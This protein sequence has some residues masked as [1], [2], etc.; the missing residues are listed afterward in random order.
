MDWIIHHLNLVIEIFGA[1][2]GLIY[3]YFSIRQNIWLWPLG[4]FTSSVYI[5]V[6]FVSKFYADMGLQGYYLVV[7]IYGWYHWLH[8][9]SGNR[10][11]ELPVSRTSRRQWVVLLIITLVLFV[12]MAWV[13]ER[14]TDSDV[15]RWD[16]FTTAASITAT[17]MLARKLLEHWLI[18]VVVD[19]VSMGLYV[20]KGLY[21]TVG[22]F[23]VYTLM[24]V[25]GYV[26]WKKDL[27]QQ[28]KV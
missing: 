22:L 18:W 9:A 23:A 21:P 12:L 16:A 11:D 26:E 10:S 20:Y 19:A 3:L 17:W 1:V 4:I 7:S 13:L 14:F 15:P 8:G 6:F 27:L 5:Y 25:K 2:T 28:N 24:A